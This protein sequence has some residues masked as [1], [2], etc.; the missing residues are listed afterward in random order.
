[1]QICRDT[2]RS[3]NGGRAK[4]T[5]PGFVELSQARQRRLAGIKACLAS[6]CEQWQPARTQTRTVKDFKLPQP[7]TRFAA[8]VIVSAGE[9]PVRCGLLICP[10]YRPRGK[11]DGFV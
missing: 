7:S 9:A 1:M 2:G 11:R 8:N 4:Q 10:R 6:Q 3:V 5:G